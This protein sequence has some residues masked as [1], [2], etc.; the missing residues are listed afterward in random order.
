[1]ARREGVFLRTSK[2]GAGHHRLRKALRL[3]R[4]E[5]LLSVSLYASAGLIAATAHPPLLLVFI[6][7]LQGTVYACSPIA[8]LWNLRAQLV[9]AGEFRRRHEERRVRQARNRRPLLRVAGLAAALVLA[10]V[11]G[12]AAASLAAPDTL[13]PGSTGGHRLGHSPVRPAP[14]PQQAASEG[15]A[16]TS[17]Q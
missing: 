2:T 4:W 9:P 11:V 17:R 12:A 6:I 10:A 8:S 13:L 3:T 7:A 5:I 15:S 1:M 16:F 14:S